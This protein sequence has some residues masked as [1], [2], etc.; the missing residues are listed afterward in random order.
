VG[1]RGDLLPLWG[2]VLGDTG[3]TIQAVRAT[4]DGGWVVA[5][6]MDGVA[7]LVRL[8]TG[9][10]SAWRRDLP[11]WDSAGGLDRDG[12]DLLV[13]GTG[14]GVRLARVAADGTIVAQWSCGSGA[15]RSAGVAARPDGDV[16]FGA[17]MTGE[18]ACAPGGP[19]LGRWRGQ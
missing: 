9:G 3:T 2:R 14:A 13:S 10:S 18:S 1:I 12:S 6:E 17:A 16:W 11:G 8:N 7:T 19:V 4:T 5:G 15:D